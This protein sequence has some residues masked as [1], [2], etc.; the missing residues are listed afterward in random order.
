MIKIVLVGAGE[1]VGCDFMQQALLIRK[2]GG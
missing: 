2:I 1:N